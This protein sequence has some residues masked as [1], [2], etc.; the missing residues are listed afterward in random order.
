M[1]RP[2]IQPANR[3]IV[4]WRQCRPTDVRACG[5]DPMLVGWYDC[6]TNYTVSV[7]SYSANVKNDT[8]YAL[9]QISTGAARFF[10]AAGVSPGCTE[11]FAR[12]HSI[13]GKQVSG[14]TCSLDR[15]RFFSRARS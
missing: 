8:A 2:R 7:S 15:N 9:G 6:E 5:D 13:Y 3:R 14:P 1:S 4:F 10:F 11:N 12:L